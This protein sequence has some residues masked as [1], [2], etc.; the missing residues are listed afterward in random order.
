MRKNQ[1]A[2]ALVLH[3]HQGYTVVK[4]LHKNTTTMRD[5]CPKTTQQACWN[6][7]QQGISSRKSQ[8]HIMS[9]SYHNGQHP[10]SCNII[11][12]ALCPETGYIRCHT[13]FRS[14]KV[15][16]LQERPEASGLFWCR[17]TKIQIMLAGTVTIHHKNAITKQAWQEMRHM[18]KF[19][20]CANIAP[21]TPTETA[22]TGFTDEQWDNRKHIAE[23][24]EPYE[25]FSI[26]ELQIHT[27]EQLHLSASGHT[28]IMFT[29]NAGS[30]W[31][32]QWLSP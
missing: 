32:H 20:Y 19:C 31:Q 22:C 15:K 26:L 28:K 8:Y 9:L 2:I 10:Q 30:Q 14:R 3:T 5:L 12:R 13:D 17:E 11:P 27:M 4:L 16:H 18:S 21:N 25:N 23:T 1:C 24:S 7:I 29:R 6:C